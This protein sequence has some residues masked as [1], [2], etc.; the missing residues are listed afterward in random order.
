MNFI[1]T[2]HHYNHFIHTS[3]YNEEPRKAG[4]NSAHK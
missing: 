1:R 4:I 3:I 2:Y